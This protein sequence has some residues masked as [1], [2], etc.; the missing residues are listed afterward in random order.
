MSPPPLCL[1]SWAWGLASRSVH[2]CFLSPGGHTQHHNF[3]CQ[4]RAKNEGLQVC[5][6]H[7][8]YEPIPHPAQWASTLSKGPPQ[9]SL[10]PPVPLRQPARQDLGVLTLQT[11]KWALMIVI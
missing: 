2:N 6:G 9:H 4:L 1:P 7:V 10:L 5:K 8:L 3:K 11:E